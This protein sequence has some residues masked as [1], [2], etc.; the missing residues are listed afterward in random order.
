MGKASTTRRANELWF[1]NQTYPGINTAT[2][3]RDEN[4]WH[5]HITMIAVVVNVYI[6][7][8]SHRTRITTCPCVF[9]NIIFFI[10]S[11]INC[12]RIILYCYLNI[13]MDL[14]TNPPQV[15]TTTRNYVTKGKCKSSMRRTV[16]YD[17]RNRFLDE[18][19][20]EEKSNLTNLKKSRVYWN[21]YCCTLV[22]VI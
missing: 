20:T 15:C 16:N 10:F 12:M 8:D 3:K 7:R 14:F 5:L 2:R 19:K 1:I 11:V 13:L 9:H 18:S 17:W 21:Y 22:R 6:G 4:R